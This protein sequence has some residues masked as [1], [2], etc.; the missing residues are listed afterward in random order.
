MLWPRFLAATEF[1][2]WAG[3]EGSLFRNLFRVSGF[4]FFRVWL[5][6]VGVGD[7]DGAAGLEQFGGWDKTRSSG[8]GR[9]KRERE[10]RGGF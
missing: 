5:F 1:L 7:G 9:G 3:E 6:D 8:G 4:F 10:K 2:V